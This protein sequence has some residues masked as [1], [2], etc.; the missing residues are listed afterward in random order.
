[1]NKSR[2]LW[3]KKEWSILEV[4]GLSTGSVRDSYFNA[5]KSS[6][7]GSLRTVKPSP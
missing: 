3:R 1:M 7:P 6:T 5:N 4:Y 2:L